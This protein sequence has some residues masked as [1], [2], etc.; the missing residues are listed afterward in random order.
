MTIVLS[1]FITLAVVILIDRL[2]QAGIRVV[3]Y[4]A[5]R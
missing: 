2:K 1:V 4:H 3:R 5:L